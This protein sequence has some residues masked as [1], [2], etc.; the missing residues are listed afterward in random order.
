MDD[1]ILPG[2]KCTDRKNLR[3]SSMQILARLRASIPQ[4]YKDGSAKMFVLT[5][6]FNTKPCDM[7]R[8][9]IYTDKE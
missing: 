1:V 2:E 4:H 8:D 3:R 9:S 6:G 7:G 5:V